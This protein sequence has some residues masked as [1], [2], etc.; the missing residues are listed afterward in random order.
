MIFTFNLRNIEI[1]LIKKQ[2]KLERTDKIQ[3]TY[4]VGKENGSKLQTL[5]LIA[6]TYSRQCCWVATVET[7]LYMYKFATV[8]VM[9]QSSVSLRSSFQHKDCRSNDLI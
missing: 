9:A 7:Q 8:G 5:H 2:I 3:L 6:A 1:H 4:Q